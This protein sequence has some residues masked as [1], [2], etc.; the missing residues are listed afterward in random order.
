VSRLNLVGPHFLDERLSGIFRWRREPT[1]G[2]VI[3]GRPEL[4]G[5]EDR[6]VLCSALTHMQSLAVLPLDRT[7][8]IGAQPT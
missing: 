2:G 1:L 7:A 5:H 4:V 8:V 3:E 6:E